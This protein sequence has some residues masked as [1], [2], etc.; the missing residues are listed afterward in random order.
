MQFDHILKNGQVA[1]PD[2]QQKFGIRFET[3]DIGLL[4]GKIAEIGSLS[5]AGADQT[6]DCTGLHVFPGAIDSQVH[7]REPGLEHKEDLATGTLAALKGGITCV[8]EMPNTKPSTTNKE[9]FEEKIRRGQEKANC[10]F[11]FFIGASPDNI[12]QLPE[13]EKLPGC[14]GVKIFMGSSTGSLLVEKDEDLEK[15]LKSG[16]RRVAVHCE[17]EFRLR[18]RKSVI[19]EKDTGTHPLWRDEQTAILATERLLRLSEKTGRPV[20]VLHVTT[21]QEME[22]LQQAK[23]KNIPCTV[24]CTPQHL[25]LFAPDCY[26]RLGSF[27]QMNPPI[28]TADHKEGLWQAVQNGVVNV[29]GSDHAPHTLEEKNKPYPQSP[30]GMPGVQTMLPLLLN[31]SHNGLLSLEQL[32]AMLTSRPAKLYGLKNKG[33]I[34]KGNDADFTIIDTRAEKTIEE[35]WLASRCGWSP[36]TNEKVTGWPVGVFLNGQKALWQDEVLLTHHGKMCEFEH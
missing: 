30:S 33:E 6:T 9:A 28:R 26:D 10:H 14:V 23:A 8:F 5:S 17:D 20:H 3:T 25:T 13:L 1:L 18:E 4:D 15:I 16:T 31:H 19:V 34:I 32:C 36:F 12:A 35:P 2:S 24:E 29:F 21:K 27:A 11:G 7:F 22:L